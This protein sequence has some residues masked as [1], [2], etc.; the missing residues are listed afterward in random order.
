[1]IAIKILKYL[2]ENKEPKNILEISKAI[3]TNYSNT[4]RNIQ[5]I[6][7]VN[8]TNFGNTK[9][10]EIIPK[11]TENLYIAEFQ[12]KKELLKSEIF[13]NISRKI[14][15]S[16]NPF[17]IVL[18]FGSSIK[19]LNPN[20]IDICVISDHETKLEEELATLSYNIDLNIFTTK[21]FIEM[22]SLK[23]D[24][25]GNEILKNNIIL[26]GIESYYEILK[27]V[28]SVYIS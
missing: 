18:V 23:T 25:L 28:E 14:D 4:Y 1:M 10:I 27:N 11:L 20:D 2:L 3:N 12:R 19:R 21:E 26:K 8:I 22:I 15:K 5:N 13:Q 16:K 9:R 24:N 7:E 6:E 17:L